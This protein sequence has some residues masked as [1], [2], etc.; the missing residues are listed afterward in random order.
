MSV[1]DNIT[2]SVNK[3][4]V[5]TNRA[6]ST[7]KLKAQI[8]DALKRRQS[9][10]AQLGA[11][12]YEDTKDNEELRKGREA[13]YNAI[14]ACDEERAAYQAE[15]TRIENEAQTVAAAATCPFCGSRMGASDMFCSGCG[16]SM[17]EI[18][19][20]LTAEYPKETTSAAIPMSPSCPACGVPVGEDD[21]FCMNCGNK[22]R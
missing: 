11:S 7:M 15:I 13:L 17:A 2:S 16:K 4:I 21:T 3:G 18:Q 9:L 6:T 10:V 8:N 1:L 22:L 14:E 20:V 19:E 5:A 12:L